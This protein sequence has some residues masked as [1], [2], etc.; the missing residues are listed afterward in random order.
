MSRNVIAMLLVALALSGCA[1][2]SRDVVPTSVSADTYRELDCGQIAA[3][4]MRV[5]AQ[6]LQ[7]ERRLDEAASNDRLIAGAGMF[8]WPALFA[9][10]GRHGRRPSTHV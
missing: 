7:W 10:G 5:Q 3:E 1:T 9:L 2:A 4:G 8:F 6:A